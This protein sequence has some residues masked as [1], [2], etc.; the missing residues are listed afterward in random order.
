MAGNCQRVVLGMLAKHPVA[1]GTAQKLSG[2]S[3]MKTL[4]LLQ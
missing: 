4:S 2:F 3:G 1:A